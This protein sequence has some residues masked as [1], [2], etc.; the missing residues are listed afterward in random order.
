MYALT[1]NCLDGCITTLVPS[2]LIFSLVSVWV[3]KNLLFLL[4]LQSLDQAFVLRDRVVIPSAERTLPIC[5]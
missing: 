2:L 1:T 3:C 5:V 4:Q